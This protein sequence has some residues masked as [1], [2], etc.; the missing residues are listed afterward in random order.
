MVSIVHLFTPENTFC[1]GKLADRRTNCDSQGC[2]EP[3]NS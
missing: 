3:A 2:S 1:F